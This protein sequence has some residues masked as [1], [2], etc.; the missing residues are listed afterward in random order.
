MPTTTSNIN[1]QTTGYTIT[2]GEII[3]EFAKAKSRQAKKIILEKLTIF[4]FNNQQ[5]IF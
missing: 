1:L 3:D 2:V 5:S 4:Y